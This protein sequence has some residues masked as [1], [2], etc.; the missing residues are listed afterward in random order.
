MNAHSRKLRSRVCGPAPG[1]RRSWD[2]L[3]DAVE[4]HFRRLSARDARA[5]RELLV[6]DAVSEYDARFLC[7]YLDE[8]GPG[9]SD[10]FT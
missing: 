1:A 4:P 3:P 8:R 2:H 7:S 9:F 10:A 5:L 6:D